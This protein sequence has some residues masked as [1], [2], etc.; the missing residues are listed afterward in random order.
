MG[1]SEQFG[2]GTNLLK[3]LSILRK[4]APEHFH[5]I[6]HKGDPYYK[7]LPGTSVIV[8][9][10]LINNLAYWGCNQYIIQR[11]LGANLKT[12]RSGILFAGFLKLIVPVIV[13]LPGIQIHFSSSLWKRHAKPGVVSPI[14]SIV[15]VLRVLRKPTSH[16][17]TQ[18]ST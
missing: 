16:P 1:L 5:M 3:G 15:G 17:E 7:D 10:M 11:A 6:F 12:A 2:F 8:G 4:E 13:V 14:P 9:G 18:R